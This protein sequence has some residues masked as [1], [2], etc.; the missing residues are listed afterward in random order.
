MLEKLEE[1]HLSLLKERADIVSK[2]RRQ[3]DE[4]DLSSF[5]GPLPNASSTETEEVDEL[6]RTVPKLD[7]TQQRRERRVA[8]TARRQLRSSR[9]PRM[10]D[11]NEK[12]EEG[13]S[14]DSSL[15]PADANAYKNAQQTLA[16]GKKDV[17]SDVRA[18]E[19]REPGKG[20]WSTWREKYSESYIGAWGGL[21]VV[22]V[23]EF[24]MRLESVG[25]DCI[26]V[27]ISFCILLSM[28]TDTEFCRIPATCTVLSG[29]KDYMHTPGRDRKRSL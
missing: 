5:L 20:R 3:D 19:F 24:W 21:G 10:E 23:W 18:E 4:D 11:G 2:R 26:E 12:E 15:A 25:W 29:I 14:T 13:Y 6:G 28:R 1:R 22:N 8:R 27:F 17:L 7:E 9:R 16:I